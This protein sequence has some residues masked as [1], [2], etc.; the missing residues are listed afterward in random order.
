MSDWQKRDSGLIVPVEVVPKKPRMTREE[1][2]AAHVVC[3]ECFSE[4]IEQ[5]CVGFLPWDYAEPFQ[6]SNRAACGC[7]WSG[8]VHDLIAKKVESCEL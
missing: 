8:I 3:P 7:G 2:L 1:Y 6:D 5:T 4:T